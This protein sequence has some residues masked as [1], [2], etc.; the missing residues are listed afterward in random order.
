MAIS[1]K[2]MHPL[3]NV[4]PVSFLAVLDELVAKG[5]VHCSQKEKYCIYKYVDDLI[6]ITAEERC[7]RGLIMTRSPAAFV[8]V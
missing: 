7:A 3:A 4:D 6:D 8:K 5:R 2:N 1:K